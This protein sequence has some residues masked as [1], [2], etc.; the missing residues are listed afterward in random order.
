MHYIIVE[1]EKLS[2]ERLK[3]MTGR[4]MPDAN[5]AVILDSVRS[6]VKWLSSM[7]S[8]DLAFFD[9]QL[10]DG[11]SFEIFEQVRAEFPVIFTTAFNEYALKAFKVNSIDYLLKPI[12]EEELGAAIERF[13]GGYYQRSATLERDSFSRVLNMLDNSYKRRFLVKAGEHIRMIPVEE[14]SL[15]FSSEKSTFIRTLNGRDYGIDFSLDQLTSLLNPASFCRVNRK[16][17]V[18]LSAITDIITYSGSRLK[19]KLSVPADEDILVSRERVQ[20]FK[21]WLDR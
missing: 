13:N 7:P 21:A 1:D 3:A 10:A 2:A 12:D 18:A 16:Y 6:A 14:I 19:L 4:L 15:F 8:P 9:I 11:L 17:I 20:G 5:C